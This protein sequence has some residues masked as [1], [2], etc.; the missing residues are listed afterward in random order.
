[1]VNQLG[2]LLV[3]LAV[4]LTSLAVYLLFQLGC[5]VLY[6]LGRPHT[7]PVW[8]SPHSALDRAI[9]QLDRRDIAVPF[10]LGPVL[11][12]SKI[13]TPP[14]FIEET[15]RS[16]DDEDRQSSLLGAEKPAGRKPAGY[17]VKLGNKLSEATSSGWKRLKKISWK[18]TS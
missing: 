18:D 10:T 17:G 2:C 7:V 5:L 3:S 15:L 6:Q 11:Y 16:E 13:I 14:I 4:L 9:C 1:M 8:T 12:Y